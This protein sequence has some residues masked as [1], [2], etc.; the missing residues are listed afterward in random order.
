MPEDGRHSG[1]LH[2][3][4]PE[5]I[6]ELIALADSDLRL[7]D[8]LLARVL[9]LAGDTA[10]YRTPGAADVVAAKEERRRLADVLSRACSDPSHLASIEAALVEPP[11]D[12]RWICAFALARSGR[13]GGEI[14]KVAVE[15]LGEPDGDVRWAAAE[16][17]C[18]PNSQASD[19]VVEAASDENSARRKMA[20]Y[21]LRDL[22]IAEMPIVYDALRCEDAGVRLAALAA[23]PSLARADARAT[24]E[25]IRCM[26][27]AGEPGVRRAAAAILG[28]LQGDV[29]AAREALL[30]AAGDKSDPHF[31]RA[32]AG[33]LERLKVG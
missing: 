30:E 32:V 31:A 1:P 22:G 27:Q 18:H 13:Y 16:I 2:G 17:L 33:A 21:C 28:R 6:R 19:L 25:T 24:R 3:Q 9:A 11:F 15:A 20:L 14:S 29:Q 12:R 7:D 5:R 23:I 10:A 4:R 26:R 8:S